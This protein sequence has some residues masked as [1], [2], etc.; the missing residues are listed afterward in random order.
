MDGEEAVVPLDAVGSQR[1]V[2]K[3]SEILA[4]TP[5]ASP[6]RLLQIV[7]VGDAIGLVI[8]TGKQLEKA[9]REGLSTLPG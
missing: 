8:L 7:G 9:V 2:E 5:Q 6:G 3:A 4:S 1:E